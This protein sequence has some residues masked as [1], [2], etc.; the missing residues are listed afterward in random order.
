MR[1]KTS[2]T[3]TCL[4]FRNYHAHNPDA[5]QI[6]GA[7]HLAPAPSLQMLLRNPKKW[8][9][10]IKQKS[11]GT[12]P[13]GALPEI[14]AKPEGQPSRRLCDSGFELPPRLSAN[15]ALEQEYYSGRDKLPSPPKMTYEGWP[16]FD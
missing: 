15:R 11:L 6:L 9:Q 16:N 10:S 13:R 7:Q 1:N 3:F 2:V 12:P 4:P 5:S 14:Q 8:E